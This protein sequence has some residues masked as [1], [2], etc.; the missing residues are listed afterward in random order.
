MLSILTPAFN[1]SA[2]LEALHAR[3]TQTMAQLGRGVGVADRRRPLARRHV[4]GD[5]ASGARWIR[6]CAAS[7]SPATR[8]SHVAITC[9][10]HHVRGD[11]AVMMASDLQDPPETLGALLQKWRERRAGRLG[12][13]ARAARRPDARR[14]CRD[15]LLDHAERRRHEGDAGAR[16]RLLPRR[17]RGRS[18]RSAAATSSTSACLR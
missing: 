17:P 7:G 12:D 18:T 4:R 5:P 11:A 14:V 9:G 10:L 2:N 15:L 6:T 16:R 13:A 8:G 3:L 1:E